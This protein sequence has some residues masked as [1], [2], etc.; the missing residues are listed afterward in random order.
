MLCGVVADL[1]I[2]EVVNGVYVV[3]ALLPDAIFVG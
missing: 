2:S 3:S 1:Q